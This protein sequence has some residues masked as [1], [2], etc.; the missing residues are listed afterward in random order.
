MGTCG[1]KTP[2][3]NGGDNMECDYTITPIWSAD[4][5]AI[6]FYYDVCPESPDGAHVVYFQFSSA[7]PGPGAVVVADRNGGSP[8]PVFGV[9]NPVDTHSAARQQ[10]VDDATV[11]CCPEGEGGLKTALVALSD[12]RSRQVRGALRMVSPVAPLGLTT[13]HD[14]ASLSEMTDDAVCLM[15]LRDGA[16]RPLFTVKDALRAH[17]RGPDFPGAERVMFMHTKWSPRGTRFPV[18]ASNI[19]RIAKEEGMQ[20]I[21]S[22]FVAEADGS[23]LRYVGEEYHHSAWSA[24]DDHIL[25]FRPNA[26]GGGLGMRW[27]G[28]YQ[29]LLAIPV[30]GG[31]PAPVFTGI[32][33]KHLLLSPDGRRF[34]AD[35]TDWPRKGQGSIIIYEIGASEPLTAV[36]MTQADFGKR[37]CYIHPTRSRDGRRICFNSAEKGKRRLYG[38]NLPTN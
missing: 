38:L 31:E 21:N 36:R 4:R 35:A 30:D 14:F 6:H 17:P 29:D 13:L 7:A 20:G 23:R 3:Q 27:W 15:D 18:M 37:G 5:E 19:H 8:R 16:P 22:L 9:A 10:W 28:G 12:G 25:S 32:A 34:V 26:T 24:D 33:G 2:L 11:A 1:E